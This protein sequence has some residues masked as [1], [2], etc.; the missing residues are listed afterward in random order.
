MYEENI[1]IQFEQ[2]KEQT[3]TT[4]SETVQLA[5]EGKLNRTEPDISNGI[6]DAANSI[7]QQLKNLSQKKQELK[8]S[9]DVFGVYI[10]SILKEMTPETQK[11]KRRRLLEVLEDD[12]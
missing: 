3:P 10:A 11:M 2:P 8:T 9:A 6:V 4:N 5:S 12:E 7:T 1:I